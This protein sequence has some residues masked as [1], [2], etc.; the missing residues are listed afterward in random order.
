MEFR[1]LGPVGAGDGDRQVELGPARRRCALSVLAYAAGRPVPVEDLVDRVWGEAPPARG[2]VHGVLSRLRAAVAPV[3]LRHEQAGYLLAVDPDQVDVHRFRRLVERARSATGTGR[4]ALLREALGLWRGTPLAGLEGAWASN[5]RQAWEEQLLTALAARIATELELGEH[6]ALL[7]ELHDLVG[8]YPLVEPLTEH[9]MT[10]AYR[11]GFQA[12]AL[13]AYQALRGRLA[14]ELGV[15]PGPRLRRLYEQVLRADPELDPA[16]SR[17]TTST[18]PHD[19]ADFTGRASHVDRL[20]EVGTI[21]ALDGM[22]GVGKTALAVHVAHRLAPKYPDGQL[23]VNLHGH[24]PDREPETPGAA[25]ETLLRALGVPGEQIP[26]TTD[27]RADRWR[28]ELAGRRV[29]VVLDNAAGSA[30]VRPLL[31]GTPG[32]LTLITSRHRLTGLDVAVSVTLD[33]LDP[34]EATALFRT[35]VGDARVDAEPEAVAEVIRRCGYLPLALRVTAARLRHRPKWTVR[36]L[37]ERLAEAE[38]S[39][40]LAELSAGDRSVAAAFDLS[41]RH[42]TAEQRRLF[43]LLGLH[44]GQDIDA[45][46]A[47][48]LACLE[49]DVAERLLEELL[50]H[51]LVQQV[52]PGRYTFHDL[53]R[54]YAHVTAEAEESESGQRAAVTRVLDHYLAWA[55]AAAALLFPVAHIEEITPPSTPRPPDLPDRAAALRWLEAERINLIEVV[56]SADERGWHT[57]AVRLAWT[58]NDFL[59]AW[60]HPLEWMSVCEHALRSARTLGDRIA[61]GR[62]MQR[63]GTAE[64]ALGRIDDALSYHHRGLAIARSVGDVRGERY[65]LNA[66]GM[67]LLLAGRHVEAAGHLQEAMRIVQRAG[68]RVEEADTLN[69]LGT[70]LG[71]LGDLDGARTHLIRAH[72]LARELGHGYTVAVTLNNLGRRYLLAG[73]HREAGDHL[74]ESFDSARQFDQPAVAA[75]ALRNLGHLSLELGHHDDALDHLHRGHAMAQRH[76]RTDEEKKILLL[77]CRTCRAAGRI[78]ESLDHGQQALGLATRHGD[79]HVQA[80]A[81]D[82]LA[83]CS[84]DLGDVDAA[85]EHWSR[86]LEILT[87]LGSPEAESVARELGALQRTG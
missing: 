6:A 14:D 5:M 77:L 42:L 1:L 51:H 63:R 87:D 74:R 53:L 76:G 79:R 84:L 80:R 68:H 37:A 65:A 18:L 64:R 2:T 71:Y 22:A 3:P 50:D 17:G 7:P 86:A 20:T 57:H 9:L 30:Q 81:L 8:R 13:D 55:Y 73:R 43:R 39:R 31:P 49:V 58:L 36:Y 28:A 44:H 46:A 60:A 24:T 78:T 33:L 47:A 11:C 85:A 40:A 48:A 41:Y 21:S 82:E 69:V 66:L 75:A 12:E 52:T 15:D 72:T 10:A 29:L 25:L 56:K 62:F 27:Q 23:F 34:A 70:C 4:A 16:R 32:C 83:R 26:P 54:R 35:A 59:S 19:L 38:P 67:D 45:H 61:E